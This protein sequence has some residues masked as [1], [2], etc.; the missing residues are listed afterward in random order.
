VTELASW[1][2]TATRQAIEAFV[3]SAVRDLPEEQ[4]IAAFDNDGT[5]WCEQPMPIELGWTIVSVKDDWATVF[6]EPDG[7]G[8]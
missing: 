1:N 3:E 4:R 6:A 5:L 2:D 7:A 8:A